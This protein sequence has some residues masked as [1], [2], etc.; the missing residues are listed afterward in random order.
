[1]PIIKDLTV[2]TYYYF[3]LYK[4]KKRTGFSFRLEGKF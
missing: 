4:A 3:A 2:V 1:M